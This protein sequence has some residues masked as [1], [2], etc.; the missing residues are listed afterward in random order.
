M[1]SCCCFSVSDIILYIVAVFFPPLAVVFRSGCCSQD[2]LLNILLTLLAFLPGMIHAFYFI[3]IT[4]PVR[5]EDNRYFYQRGWSDRER[6]AGVALTHDGQNTVHR[7][8]PAGYGSIDAM[9]VQGRPNN[10]GG[11]SKASGSPPPYSELP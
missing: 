8:E 6:Y 1:A 3:T 5:N 10:N 4:S 11:E 7:P 2:L 9:L